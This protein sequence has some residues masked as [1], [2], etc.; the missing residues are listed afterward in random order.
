MSLPRCKHRHTPIT[1][2]GCFRLL[3]E[4]EKI[5]VVAEKQNWWDGKRIWYLDIEASSLNASFGITLS[6][7]LKEQGSDKILS[8]VITKQELFD[9]TFDK[10]VIQ[11]LVD[12]LE[13]NVDI[14]VTYYGK[15]YDA[16][17]VRTRALYWNIPFPGYGS[18]YHWDLYFTV[19]RNLKL[20]RHSLEVVT[21]FL[22][23][24]GKTHLNPQ[25]WVF[26]QYGNKDALNEVLEHNIQ[27]VLILEKLHERLGE[28]S[29]WTKASL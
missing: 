24:G 9:N 12:A 5:E 14:L 28:F 26:A 11:E 4:P 8:S 2:P 21:A 17:F 27:D 6:W 19:K 1:H 20:Y 18:I 29:K 13:N 16:K 23:I 22:G 15:G 10:R 7:V 25:T 3:P